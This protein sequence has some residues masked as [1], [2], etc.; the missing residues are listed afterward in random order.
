M[1]SGPLMATRCACC[2]VVNPCICMQAHHAADNLPACAL[3]GHRR[4]GETERGDCGERRADGGDMRAVWRTTSDLR[5][6]YLLSIQSC[7][8]ED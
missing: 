2:V 3:H 7:M 6:L 1:C 8:L 5:P 4:T